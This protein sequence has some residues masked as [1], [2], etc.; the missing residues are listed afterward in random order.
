MPVCTTRNVFVDLFVNCLCEFRK[1][2]PQRAALTTVSAWTSSVSLILPRSEMFRFECP[3]VVSVDESRELMRTKNAEHAEIA[4]TCRAH[5][6]S[7]RSAC[8]AGRIID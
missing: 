5:R 6:H 7:T 2:D 1:E 4:E 8:K 3:P